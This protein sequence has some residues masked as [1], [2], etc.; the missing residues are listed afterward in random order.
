MKF[1]YTF[2]ILFIIFLSFNKIYSTEEVDK[3]ESLK[4]L[5]VSLSEFRTRALEERKRALEER[6]RALVWE[7]QQLIFLVTEEGERSE[8]EELRLI[9]QRRIKDFFLSKKTELLSMAKQLK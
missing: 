8:I 4:A 7:N 1:N 3:I 6:L 9:E 5:I 2:A